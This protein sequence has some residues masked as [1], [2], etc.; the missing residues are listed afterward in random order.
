MTLAV[1]AQLN[2]RQK[3]DHVGS[4]AKG[5][6]HQWLVP[7]DFP[8]L[9]QH[10]VSRPLRSRPP[11]PASPSRRR[12]SHP[13]PDQVPWLVNHRKSIDDLP[14]SIDAAS[15][16]CRLT[17][18]SIIY[19]R[20]L[21]IYRHP[22][23]RKDIELLLPAFRAAAPPSKSSRTLLPPFQKC[24]HRT[25]FPWPPLRGL[26]SALIPQRTITAVRAKIFARKSNADVGI[27]SSLFMRRCRG[28]TLPACLP[29]DSRVCC[30]LF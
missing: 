12:S 4:P 3:K 23:S 15:C 18:L 14:K 27:L 7:E 19:R 5:L 16:L 25:L 8:R 28:E 11:Q 26:R 6:G 30:P 2:D 29:T 13:L 24:S 22:Q 17:K 20:F 9:L 21:R 1:E 10:R